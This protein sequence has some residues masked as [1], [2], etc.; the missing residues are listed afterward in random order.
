VGV[1]RSGIFLSVG[2]RGMSRKEWEEVE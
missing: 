2:K 1:G